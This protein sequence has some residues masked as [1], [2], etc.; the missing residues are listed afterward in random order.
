[1]I[2]LFFTCSASL[3]VGFIYTYRV[4]EDREVEGFFVV[5]PSEVSVTIVTDPVPVC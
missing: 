5:T 4:T 1:M 2:V 3:T